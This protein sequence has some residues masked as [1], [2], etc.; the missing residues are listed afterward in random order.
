MAIT[1]N[2]NANIG[3]NSNATREPAVMYYNPSIFGWE[4][5]FGQAI[6][7]SDINKSEV[8]QAIV[9]AIIELDGEMIAGKAY[10][11]E[12]V[13]GHF[14]SAQPKVKPADENVVITLT[15]PQG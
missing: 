4:P 10:T 8:L 7:Q 12:G 2:L 9:A 15:S 14:K 3:A 1:T 11:F 13:S 6:T 5:R